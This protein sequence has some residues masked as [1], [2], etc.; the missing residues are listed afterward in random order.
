[1]FLKFDQIK[2]HTKI[3]VTGPQRSGTTIT[4]YMLAKKLGYKFLTEEAIRVSRVDLMFNLFNEQD[5]FVLQ[6]PCMSSVCQWIKPIEGACVVF[7][8]RNLHEVHNSMA[9]I[10][11]NLAE[12]ELKRYFTDASDVVHTTYHVW[13]KFQKPFLKEKGIEVR[14]EEIQDEEG[15]I[16]KEKRVDFKPRQIVAGI[17]EA[18]EIMK[19]G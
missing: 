8:I 7:M 13:D 6:A 12:D 5:C 15:F 3:L 9:R 14:Y 19:N 17:E 18:K 10:S 16:P 1:M 4:A 2:K 11:W